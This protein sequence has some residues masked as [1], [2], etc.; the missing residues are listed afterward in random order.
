MSKTGRQISLQKEAN[1]HEI[2]REFPLP[3]RCQTAAKSRS[4]RKPIYT[5]F[6]ANFPCPKGV[7]RP[8][9]LAPK[10]S[11]STRNSPRISPAQK[12]S[13][14]RQIL[15]QKEANLHEIPREFP[16]PKRCQTAAK[17]CSKRKPI[18]TKFPANFPCPKGVKRP[19]NLAPKGSQS[20]RNSPR[21]S[22]AQKVSNGRQI[23]LQKEANLHEIPREFPLLKRCQTAAKSRSETT[24]HNSKFSANFTAK[25]GTQRL[26]GPLRKRKRVSQAAQNSHGNY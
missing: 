20:T 1:L 24:P 19:P 21:I 6:P 5:K 8:P 16:L 13:N 12:V 9:N 25:N 3:K 22:P 17:S 10:G 7:K 11:Q 4:K 26:S 18:Y 15:L 2:P 14:G 23:L